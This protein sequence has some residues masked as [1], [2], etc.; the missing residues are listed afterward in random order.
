M[1]QQNSKPLTYFKEI[2]SILL[3]TFLFTVAYS[4]SPLYTSNQNQ[5]FLHGLAAA[6]YGDLARDWLANTL[7]PTPVFSQLIRVTH[8]YI[9]VKEIY[10]LYYAALMGVYLFA[11]FNIADLLKSIKRSRTTS[12][13]FL[14][15]IILIH[16]AALRFTLS[17]FVGVNWSY[18]LED[19]IAD[20]RM[21][22]PVFQ[23]STFGVFLLLSVWLYLK[24]HRVLSVLS[25]VFAATVHPTYLF[26]AGLIT[27]AY[28]LMSWIESRKA[29]QPVMLGMVA[30]IA[31]LP[32]LYYV[33][34]T[35]ANSSPAL[36]SQA[37]YILIKLS[38][39]PSCHR[40]SMVGLHRWSKIADPLCCSCS[41]P[42]SNHNNNHARNNGE[43]EDNPVAAVCF[44]S[45]YNHDY[46]HLNGGAIDHKKRNPGPYL[47]LE[48]LHPAHSAGCDCLDL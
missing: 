4:Q 45:F 15:L 7:D 41:P 19:G 42:Y 37:K 11:L 10:Y 23:P 44:F 46:H 2:L 30:L 26:S 43:D 34:N 5:Y 24:D 28:M 8:M 20:Q 16:S 12:L 29:R 13:V 31:V 47:P 25:A 32:I 39:T 9:G 1:N 3:W 38:Y 22:G 6:R 35:F 48:D 17:R 40:E 27:G 36:S 18:I 33:L 14:A 21:L